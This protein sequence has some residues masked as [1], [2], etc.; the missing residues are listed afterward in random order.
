MQS[1]DLAAL[2]ALLNSLSAVLL[3]LAWRTI[4]GG[5]ELRHRKLM[6]S[7]TAVSAAFLVSYLTRLSLYGNTVYTGEGT[8][9]TL[10]FALL[11]SHVILAAALVPLVLTTLALA[12]RGRRER[13]RRIAR[14]TWPVWMYVS[15]TGV[16]IYLMLYQL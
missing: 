11:V 8:V 13:H 10:Y 3:F 12:L 2:N 15:V 9:R 1:A 5:D 14:F 4:R 16:L 7:A 6:L